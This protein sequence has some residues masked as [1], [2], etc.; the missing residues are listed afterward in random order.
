LLD[1][2][3]ILLAKIKIGSLPFLWLREIERLRV[4]RKE[5]LV[6]APVGKSRAGSLS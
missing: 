4:R 6:A 2:G 5:M 1:N 3:T